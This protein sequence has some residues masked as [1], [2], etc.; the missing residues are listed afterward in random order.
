M[1]DTDDNASTQQSNDA[2]SPLTLVFWGIAPW[3][4]VWLALEI[5]H[6]AILAFIFY[7]G[8]CLAGSFALR[9]AKIAPAQ[10]EKS[11]PIPWRNL[12]IGTI[13]INIAAVI[14]Y[15]F[16]GASIFPA[17]E[18][19]PKLAQLGVTKASFWPIALYFTF[20]NPLIEERF[21]RGAILR[22]WEKILAPTQAVFLSGAFFAAWHFLP[23]RLFVPSL[24]WLIFG[25]G[26]ILFLGIGLGAIVRKTGRLTEAIFMHAFAADLPVMIILYWLLA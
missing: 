4:V 2:P 3:P 17:E 10:A 9:H 13:I 11:A 15:K 25:L 19:V 18:V 21:W 7:H 14:L 8:V 23:T 22:Y 26:A 24:P 1:S 12:L 16:V 6:S 20:I 5:F